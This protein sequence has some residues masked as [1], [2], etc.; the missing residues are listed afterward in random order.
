MNEQAGALGLFHIFQLSSAFSIHT[1]ETSKV[2]L[3]PDCKASPRS[4]L[5]T[6]KGHLPFRQ[7]SLSPPKLSASFQLYFLPSLSCYSPACSTPPLSLSSPWLRLPTPLPGIYGNNSLI[8]HLIPFQPT[9]PRTEKVSL[10]NLQIIS[11]KPPA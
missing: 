1:T 11:P 4:T 7:P 10:L 2:S 6:L 8:S 9:F 3:T 5:E